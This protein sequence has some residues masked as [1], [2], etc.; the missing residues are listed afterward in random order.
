[1]LC[2]IGIKYSLNVIINK[3][4]RDLAWCEVPF[5]LVIYLNS[6]AISHLASGPG[7]VYQISRGEPTIS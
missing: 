3:M 1:M 5:H 4:K 7:P 6:Q 2:L